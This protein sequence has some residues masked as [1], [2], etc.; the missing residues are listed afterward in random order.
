M[1]LTLIAAM[2]E[3]G[4]V[5]YKGGLPWHCPA[6]LQHFKETTLDS[7]MIMGRHTYDSFPR[8]LP[9]RN[10]IVVTS[11][12]LA[13]HPQVRAVASLEEA[14]E[15]CDPAVENFHI[16]GPTLWAAALK[17]GLIDKLLI[18]RIPG[19]HEVDVSF[20]IR[21]LQA[22]WTKDSVQD[23]RDFALHTYLPL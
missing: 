15:L 16:G 3:G 23:F 18:S 9:H 10:H 8:P 12:P 5:G 6:D 20:P 1:T 14:L 17:A 7:T 13:P 21:P 2:D 4:G 22:G 19:I 11:R